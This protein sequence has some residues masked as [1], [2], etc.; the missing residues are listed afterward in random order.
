MTVLGASNLVRYARDRPGKLTP[1]EIGWAVTTL[2]V[3][4]SRSLG[5]SVA[6][7]RLP[8]A[9]EVTDFDLLSV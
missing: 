9:P 8:D 6:Q 5:D 1:D 7:A 2:D 3:E 4:R